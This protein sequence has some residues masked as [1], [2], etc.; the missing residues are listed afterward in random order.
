VVTDEAGNQVKYAEY[1]PFGE[2]KVEQGSLSV[3]RKFTGK[4]LD[5][6]TGLYDFLARFYDA[7]T[8]R[9]IM[10]DPIEYSDEGIKLAGGKDLQTF[11]ANPQNL[12]KYTYCLNNPIRYLDPDGLLTILIHGTYSSSNMFKRDF[13]ESVE[14]T[15]NE[16]H[17]T[18]S[19]LWSG[20]NTD[21][22]RV[23]GAQNLANLINKYK[24]A[25]GEKLN[26][27]AHSHGGNVTFLASQENLQHK[28]DNLVTLGTPIREYR[29]NMEN[30]SKIYNVY[31]GADYVQI[32]GGGEKNIIGQEYGAASRTLDD[33][34]NI[35]VQLNNHLDP[36]G[37]LCSREVWDRNIDQRILQ[38]N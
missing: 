32:R 13:V 19:L 26:I 21:R 23:E 18:V 33:A 10:A 1:K 36:H 14:R 4:E 35:N 3:K 2:T 17:A 20:G 30:I 22:A 9:F 29:P 31:A 34:T 25:E 37:S 38:G 28:I 27:V 16:Q 5:D 6:S 7:K 15:F 11:L 24:F 12:N 8:G